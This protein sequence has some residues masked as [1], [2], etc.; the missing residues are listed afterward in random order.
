[1][2]ALCYT[3]VDGRDRSPEL[4]LVSMTTGATGL[5]SSHRNHAVTWDI[6]MICQR[7]QARARTS[8]VAIFEIRRLKSVLSSD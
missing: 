3:F 4:S 8:L 2:C 1:M 5:Q 7:I 6:A